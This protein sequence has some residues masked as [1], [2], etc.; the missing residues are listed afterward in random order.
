MIFWLPRA[1]GQP[2]ISH[3]AYRLDEIEPCYTRIV[4]SI[5]QTFLH[6]LLIQHNE[7][8]TPGTNTLAIDMINSCFKVVHFFPENHM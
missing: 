4:P 1:T 2:L 5:D 8:H 7:G 3:P 6:L